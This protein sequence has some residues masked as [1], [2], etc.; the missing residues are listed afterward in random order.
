MA[1]EEDFDVER[2]LPPFLASV[3]DKAEHI[4]Q[5][6]VGEGAAEAHAEVID[7]SIR[8]LYRS[9][10]D[11][12]GIGAS[13]KEELDSLAA[14]FT[15]VLS[16][17]SYHIAIKSVTP[18]TGDETCFAPGKEEKETPGRPRFDIPAEMLEE[19][20]ELR[21]SWIKIGVML[22]VSRWTIHWK[23][24]QYG[25]QNM[26]GFHH[27]PDEELDEIVRGFISDHG[28][29]TGQGYV[30][31]YIKALGLRIQRKRIGE[32]MARVDPQNTALRWGVVVLHE[33]PSEM[34]IYG[35][36]P[37]GPSPPERDNHIVI[38]PVDLSHGDLLESFVLEHLDP[39]RPST[40]MG[41][42]IYT[43]A[44][45]LVFQ[46]LEKLVDSGIHLPQ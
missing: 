18:A 26:T 23:V 6:D 7:Q 28:R 44:L 14:A 20:R 29:T 37:Q 42:D 31:G 39:L 1:D 4:W 16:S 27:L 19:L 46:R 9:I 11:C 25:L 8:M 40:E 36:D 12:R 10:R 35:Y 13:D 17:L 3:L 21:F 15:D 24:E 45:E 22:G 30:G 43:E 38:D 33:E 34:E 5:N 2:D 41:A 32:S